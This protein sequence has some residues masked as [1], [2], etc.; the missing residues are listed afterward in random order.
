L[1]GALRRSVERLATRVRPW[2]ERHQNLVSRCRLPSTHHSPFDV[3]KRFTNFPPWEWTRRLSWR[4]RM[5]NRGGGSFSSRITA[6]FTRVATCSHAAYTSL[7][8][9]ENVGA[10]HRLSQIVT[11]EEWSWEEEKNPFESLG[12]APAD[13]I[14]VSVFVT[15]RYDGFDTR[16][17]DGKNRASR[18]MVH[19]RHHYRPPSPQPDTSC[20]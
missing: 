6:S 8:F 18:E 15:L 20:T 11:P 17:S 19:V 5:R 2:S 10:G 13:E 16:S 1:L 4:R 7:Y 12:A 3:Q 9:S 14:D